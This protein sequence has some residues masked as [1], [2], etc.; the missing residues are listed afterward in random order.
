MFAI[1]VLLRGAGEAA[2]PGPPRV[3]FFASYRLLVADVQNLFRTD[4]HAVW[5]LIASALYRDGLAAVFTFGAV[6]AVSV[7]GIGAPT[8]C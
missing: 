6:L 8:G 5:F 4:R 3:G 2:R 1:P 7:Y